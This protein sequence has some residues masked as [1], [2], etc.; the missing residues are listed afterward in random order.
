MN[1]QKKKKRNKKYIK[2]KVRKILTKLDYFQ[3]IIMLLNK[4]LNI[5]KI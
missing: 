5:N 2:K 4:N 3:I 1:K